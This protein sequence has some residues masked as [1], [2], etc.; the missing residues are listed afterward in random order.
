[1]NFKIARVGPTKNGVG[2]LI[3]RINV[4]LWVSKWPHGSK[5]PS[6]V[7]R[8]TRRNGINTLHAFGRDFNWMWASLT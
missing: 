2:V 7:S 3:G 6:N 5:Y 4:N 1:M 8:L